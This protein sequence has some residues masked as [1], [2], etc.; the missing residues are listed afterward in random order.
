MI[1]DY[2]RNEEVLDDDELVTTYWTLRRIIYTIVILVT[3][4]AFLIYIFSPLLTVIFNP[5]TPAPITIPLD[6]A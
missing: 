3:L 2:A 6:R 1:D 5:P 4:I